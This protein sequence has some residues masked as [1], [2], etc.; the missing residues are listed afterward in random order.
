MATL[1]ASRCLIRLP[2]SF[3]LIH[4]ILCVWSNL[5]WCVYVTEMGT[6]ES[7]DMDCHTAD[8]HSGS[9]SQFHFQ[10]VEN[11]RAAHMAYEYIRFT[12]E[13]GGQR[14]YK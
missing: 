10:I 14:R 6:V 4:A 7:I 9:G 1:E 8:S 11:F 2:W 5:A 3:G 12:L 13:T